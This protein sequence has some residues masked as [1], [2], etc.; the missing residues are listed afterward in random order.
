MLEFYM[1]IEVDRIRKIKKKQ[2]NRV[3]NNLELDENQI[4]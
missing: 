1:Q 3:S 4:V 2:G